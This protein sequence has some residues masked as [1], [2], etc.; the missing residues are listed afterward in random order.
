[1]PIATQRDRLLSIS[2]K[3]PY[4]TLLINKFSCRETISELFEIEVELLREE[5]QEHVFKFTP[6]DEREIIGQRGSVQVEQEDGGGRFFTG[7]FNHFSMI[8]RDRK[9]S[10]YK[11]TI[12]PHVWKL[13]QIF[14]SKI[15]QH[16]S[17]PDILTEVLDGFEVRLELTRTYKKRNYCVQH[18]ETDFDF[19]SRLMEEEGMYYYF[20]H[21]AD[22]ER[23]VIRDEY[24]NP[25]DCPN[26]SVIPVF[27]AEHQGKDK[28]ES[29]VSDFYIAHSLS[30]GKFVYWDHNFELPK[31][32]LDTTQTSRFN[33][34]GN[35][36]MEV[37]T[38]P[39]RYARKFDG[40]DR[41]GGDQS[42]ELQNIFQDNRDS[43]TNQML[44]R[45]AASKK[46]SGIS[47]CS[48]LTAGYRWELTKHPNNE[49]N[50]HYVLVSVNH[51]ADQ[52]PGYI[53]GDVVGEAYQNVFVAIPHGSGH[54]EFRPALKTPR[55][56][57]NGTQTAYVVGPGGEEIFTDK[58]G[59][60]KVQ[61]HWDRHGGLDANSS[62]WLRVS[63][64][65]AG[66]RW[67]MM[68]IPRIGMEVIV[69]FLNADP[70]Q[71]I[72]TGCVYNPET[73]PPYELPAEQTKS[74]IK[75]D[76]SKRRRRLQR[77]QI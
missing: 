65:W 49:M 3:L 62:C 5:D 34:G 64:A 13:T 74:T 9:F 50:G 75:S 68:F 73:M 63:Q 12:V 10:K 24:K 59:R 6:V 38:Y 14:G 1:M 19:I 8:G 31:K 33:L 17:V 47:N 40:M 36:S 61:F 67:G 30:S 37:Y 44:A 43:A 22:T 11:A 72:I 48:S 70:D 25:E 20:E 42:G 46:V 2:T 26:K 4:D 52:Q 7:I 21:T 27:D 58:Y 39:G 56:I 23:M 69:S 15:F 35:Q 45:D 71:P 41:T 55:P 29:T 51:S 28:W 66:N 16:I 53:L 77:I 57:A 76:S 60:V 54:P 18:Q 32:K